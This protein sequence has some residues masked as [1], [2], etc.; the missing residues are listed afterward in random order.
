MT[1]GSGFVGR[2]LVP[3]LVRAGHEV[4]LFG[5]RTT[6]DA[7]VTAH[8]VDLL[9]D[10]P[11]PL[12]LAVQPDALVHLAWEAT[13][14]SFW[15]APENLDWVA[16]S[17]RLARSFALAGGRRIVVAGTC[18]EYDW[19]FLRLEEERTPLRPHT[20]YG[21]AKA[22][23]LRL[24]RAAAPGLGLSLAWGRIFFPYGPFERPGRLLSSLIDGLAAG[25]RV[26]VTDGRQQRDF[27]HVEDVARAF[28]LLLES[29]LQGPINIASGVARPVRT[30]ILEVARR[31]GREDLVD[32][33]A[34]STQP[35]E[36]HV[37]IADA[38]RIRAIGFEPVWSLEAGLA[39]AVARRTG[40]QVAGGEALG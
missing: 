29:N 40:N 37:M 20:L 38:R 27:L 10:D 22:S 32:L 15:Q 14:G 25:Q 16:T 34:R 28:A 30:L 8:G 5:R 35:G 11:G 18:A 36:P 21:V 1:G 17:V 23:L 33:G 12:L 39:D 4:H 26:A 3:I 7:D 13:P 6:P 31:M 24:L 9:R 2:A 19:S